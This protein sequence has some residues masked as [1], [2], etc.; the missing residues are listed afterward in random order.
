MKQR[1]INIA[2]NL[3]ILTIILVSFLFL[4]VLFLYCF[5]QLVLWLGSL[6]GFG[7]LF[8]SGLS[9]RIVERLSS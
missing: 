8:G 5:K 6:L 1:I 4:T 9:D 2:L 7:A 3:L